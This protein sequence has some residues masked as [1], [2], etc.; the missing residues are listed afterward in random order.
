MLAPVGLCHSIVFAEILLF[1][2]SQ[3]A[4]V[5]LSRLTLAP[6]KVILLT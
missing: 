1:V 4:V 5:S 6:R 2:K 3:S